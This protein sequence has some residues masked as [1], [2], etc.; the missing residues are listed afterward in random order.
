MSHSISRFLDGVA[1]LLDIT[2]RTDGRAKSTLIAALKKFRN[3]ND[4]DMLAKDM[5]AVG[6][7]IKTAFIRHSDAR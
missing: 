4:R 7:D 3:R 2:P 1:S 5:C 6:Q